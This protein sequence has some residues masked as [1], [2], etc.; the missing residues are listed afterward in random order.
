MQMSTQNTL[1]HNYLYAIKFL[2]IC[3]AKKA[4]CATHEK[5]QNMSN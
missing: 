1:Q 2:L 4:A 3:F 5:S